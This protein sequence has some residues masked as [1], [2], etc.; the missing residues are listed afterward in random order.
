MIKFTDYI[1]DLIQN[2][3]KAHAD[4]ITLKVTFLDDT[5]NL[6][7][8]DDGIGMTT[9]V[10]NQ[11][12]KFEY[13]SN[14][15]RTVGLG[16]SMIHDLCEQTN[17][18]FDIDSIYHK[19]TNLN[20]SFNYKHIDF[21]NFGDLGTLVSDLYMHQELIGFKFVYCINKNKIIYH[22][23]KALLEDIRSFKIKKFIEEDINTNLKKVE[24]CK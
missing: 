15:K 21:P 24:G 12:R 5:L 16:L 13:T 18:S 7:I 23:P 1:Y 6:S 17:G 11:V 3:I 14:Q 8:I 4:L 19:G 10:L 2:S 22:L 20:L 9:E